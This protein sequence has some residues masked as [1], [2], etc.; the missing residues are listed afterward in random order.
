MFLAIFLAV[1]AL[2]TLVLAV[3]CALESFLELLERLK[4]K[5]KQP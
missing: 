3:P 4:R 5:T 1:I 2:F